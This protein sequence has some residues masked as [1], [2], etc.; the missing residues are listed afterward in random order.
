M[1]LAIVDLD[2][3]AVLIFPLLL[4]EF[5]PVTQAQPVLFLLFQAQHAIFQFF[6]AQSDLLR[7]LGQPD[8]VSL[9]RLLSLQITFLDG[10]S[11]A[12]KS[13]SVECNFVSV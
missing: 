8:S 10:L 9:H 3:L 4:S 12:R 11:P 5:S 6:F 2:S 7:V 1:F 13:G